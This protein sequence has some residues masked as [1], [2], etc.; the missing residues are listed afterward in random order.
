MLLVFWWMKIENR[1]VVI[2]TLVNLFEGRISVTEKVILKLK[3]NIVEYRKDR[4]NGIYI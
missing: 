1:D 3:L 2:E 4:G